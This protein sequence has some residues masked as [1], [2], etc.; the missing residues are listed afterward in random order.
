MSCLY[1]A[2]YS[3]EE[4]WDM[5][6]GQK[7]FSLFALIAALFVAMVGFAPVAAHA[8][9]VELPEAQNGV[10]TLTE[11]TT[12]SAWPAIDKSLT[13]DL[14]GH[15]L[16]YTGSDS[17][18]LNGGQSLTVKG[19]GLAANG[20]GNGTKAVFNIQTNSS[21]TLENV[22][23]HT[24]GSALLPQGDAASVTVR[25]SK[26][27]CGVY[28][29][30]TNANTVENHG[31]VITLEDSDF[32]TDSG[33]QNH[34]G[35][36]CPVLINVP[37]TLNM[38]GCVVNGTRQGV[39]V[40]GGTANIS[41]ST[42]NLTPTQDDV[43]GIAGSPIYNGVDKGNYDAANWADGNNLPMAA[44]VI[45]NRST[46]YA[47]PATCSLQGVRVN[48]PDDY[49]TVYV[50]G[51]GRTEAVDRSVSFVYDSAS[52]VGTV[53][54]PEGSV[55]VAGP[56]VATVN[57]VQFP[58]V[59]TAIDAAENNQTVTLVE[60]AK[61]DAGVPHGK[62]VV[63]DLAGH[64]LSVSQKHGFSV[65]GGLTI[66]DT[67]AN[68]AGVIISDDGDSPIQVDGG[69]LVMNSGSIEAPKG[70]GVYVLND[71]AV[72]IDGGTI[73]SLDSAL[74]GNNTT[75]DMNFFVNGGVLTAKRGPAIYMPGQCNL[76]ISGGTL[77]G[78]ISLRMGQVD[79]NGGT[80]NATT[81]AVDDFKNY[82]DY[83]G[84][85]WLADAIF[86]FGG[87]YESSNATYGNS[88][89]I[90]ITGGTIN[91]ANGKGAAVAIYDIA[92]TAQNA[93]VEIGGDAKLVTN[94]AD[95]DAY[96]VLTL[97]EAGVENPKAGYGNSELEGKVVSTISG[98]TFSSMPDAKYLVD[99]YVAAA[100]GNGMFTVAKQQ[101]EETEGNTSGKVAADGVVLDESVSK[102]LAGTAHD[103]AQSIQKGELAN[104]VKVSDE[105]KLFADLGEV[106]ENDTVTTTLNVVAA[107]IEQASAEDEKLISNMVSSNEKVE[108]LDLSVIMTIAVTK[109]DG[110]SKTAS[111]EVTE[112][113]SKMKVTVATD[114]DL[115]GSVRIAR[116]HDG[117]VDILN[118]LEVN[119]EAKTVTFETDRFSTYAILTAANCTVTFEANGGTPAPEAQTVAFGDKVVKPADP[120]KDGFTFEGWFTDAECTKVF[121]F[122]NAVTKDMPELKLYAGWTKVTERPVKKFTVTVIYGNGQPDGK[123][124]VAEGEKFAK[125]A[126]P[127]P[128]EGYEFAGWFTVKNGDNTLSGAYDFSKPVTSDL[129]I[130]AGWTPMDVED[131]EPVVKP[132]AG[133]DKPA[134]GERPADKSA[135]ALPQT[136]DT[137]ALPVVAVAGAG[138][139]A[140]AAGAVAFKRRRE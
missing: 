48:A 28:A 76:A 15:T 18:L 56:A 74:S 114:A 105:K 4:G 75:G 54:N 78:G 41:G 55:A 94:A 136:G 118:P 65:M 63:L 109:D 115:S 67:S 91:C 93:K 26:I 82:Y 29:V 17:L 6:E 113:P 25:N 46:A 30:S 98:G 16:T 45:G 1:V 130:Y 121:D 19:G 34:D 132:G 64:K 81:G 117:K 139:I 8:E 108:Y 83:S 134:K 112:L 53:V 126:D 122:D 14:A 99:G 13:I 70:Y 133:D 138:T 23:M 22:V 101:A 32:T 123:F 7:R 44:L 11:D 110:T 96:E 111:A 71:G 57:G 35:D 72:T 124:E 119:A 38:S 127:K 3:A 135:S 68:N 66:Q 5:G 33:Y 39:V 137:S 97:K 107:P 84:N 31:V 102:K 10:I 104:G 43:E 58:S 27:Y 42:I 37:G 60:D 128:L 90:S 73:E 103:V 69:T 140:L 49:N 36:S 61:G 88:L 77:N 85:V 20:M 95:R 2:V 116:V 51:M 86:V 87:C 120:V 21:A 80:I 129:T 92:K 89:N 47:Y 24:N 50:Y 12:V 9:A 106:G 100:D 125:P 52:E 40:R 59:Q 62:S 79:I 131:E